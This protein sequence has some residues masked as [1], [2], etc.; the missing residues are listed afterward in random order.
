MVMQHYTTNPLSRSLC[1]PSDR[2]FN[3]HGMH[4]CSQVDNPCSALCFSD[5]ALAEVEKEKKMSFIMAWEESEKT[6]AE[7]K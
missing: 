2:L 3:F 7:N 4:K 5:I 1:K 6:K